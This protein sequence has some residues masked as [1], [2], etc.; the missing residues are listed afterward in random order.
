MTRSLR[1]LALRAVAV[2]PLT[3]DYSLGF[4]LIGGQVNKLM[5]VTIIRVA[6]AWLLK[7]STAK[8]KEFLT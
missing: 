1:S 2:K 6:A 3:L 7:P 4:R 5:N 8:S